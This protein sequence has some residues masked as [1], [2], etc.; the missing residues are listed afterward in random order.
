MIDPSEATC[1]HDHPV[2]AL[3]L[4]DLETLE[5]AAAILRAMADPS[6]LRLL[7]RLLRGGPHCVSELASAE[8]A[9]MSTVSQRLR[10][11]RDQH[12][13]RGRRE[14]KHV[15]YELVDD[16]VAALVRAAL[17]HAAERKGSEP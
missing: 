5:R 6:R 3:E 4:T 2:R 8:K 7:E 15:Y 14:A 9:G 13:V 10:L 1:D 12:L 11:L 16:H 17:E